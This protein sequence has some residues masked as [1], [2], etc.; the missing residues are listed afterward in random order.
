MALN[1]EELERMIMDHKHNGLDGTKRL[2]YGNLVPQ[3]C[4]VALSSV[5]VT[6]D[7]DTINTNNALKVF[8]YVN[9]LSGAGVLNLRFN[10]DTGANYSHRISTNAAAF[11]NT[12]G[13]TKMDIVTASNADPVWYSLDILNLEGLAKVVVGKGYQSVAAGGGNPYDLTGTWNNT[14]D[15]ISSIQ[16]RVDGA[17]TLSEE[18]R[19]IVWSSI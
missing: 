1:N 3:V 10:S 2:N 4:R 8:I 18:S 14:S 6:L 13:D 7:T 12:T 17:I 19:I 9:G 11:S 5:N 16:V 15:L